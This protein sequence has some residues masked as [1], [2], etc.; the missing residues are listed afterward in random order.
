MRIKSMTATFGRLA[1]ESLELE[2]GLNLI[3]APNESGKSTWCAFLKAMFYG[4]DTRDRDRKGYLADKN[5]YQP[6]SGAP[7]AGEMT[8]EWRGRDITL[9]RG[10]KGSAPFAAFSAVY[11]GTEEAVSGLT[12]ENCGQVL[13]GAG[14][15]MYERAAFLGQSGSLAITSAP[16]LE[17]RIA[18]LVSSGEEDVSFSQAQGRLREWLNRRKVN[19]SVGRIPQLEEE[20]ARVRSQRE[21]LEAL[22]GEINRSQARR[23]ELE[24]RCRELA[25]ELEIHRRLAR[26]DLNRRFA[27]AGAE[28]EKARRELAELESAAP[29]PDREELKRAQGELSYLSALEPEIRG[30]EEELERAEEELERAREQARDGRFPGQSVEEAAVSVKKVQTD[31]AAAEKNARAYGQLAWVIPLAAGLISVVM[32]GT[33]LLGGASPASVLPW[34]ALLAAGAAFGAL[35]R[36][37]AQKFRRQREQ[38][39]ARFSVAAPEELDGVLEGYRARCLRAEQAEQQARLARESLSGRQARRERAGEELLRF[40]RTFAPETRDLSGCSAALSGA[41]EL[42]ERRAVARARLEGARRL[43][44]ELRAQGGQEGDTLEYLAPPA[45]T[46][47]QTAALLGEAQ[48]RLEQARRGLDMAL[49]RQKAVGD[50]AALAAR[51]EELEEEL[52]RRERE[53]RAI[54]LAMDALEQANGRLQQR[55]S[56]QLNQ[57]AAQLFSRLTGGAYTR[58]SLTRE[59]EAAAAGEEDV[60]P[61]RSLFLSKGTVDQ[62]Y[63]AVRLAVYELCLEESRPPLVL[64]DALAAFDEARMGRAMELLLE[65]SQRE[66]I[67]LFTCHERERRWLSGRGGEGA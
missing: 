23:L 64:D 27:Q 32:A 30:G 54:S 20:L 2:S 42:E 1:G 48:A 25:E 22:N 62:L 57:R 45:R 59:L 31:C 21:E 43:H 58:L 34:L 26:H 14:R 16:E 11:A 29:L 36:A 49:G 63:L 40:V 52:A 53:Y 19:K 56:P 35:Q 17:R 46:P 28:L 3:Q 44:E 4:I 65:L 9:R 50:P 15:E 51:Q 38:L 66:Q 39:L 67:L 18:A 61:R 10:P 12:G 13:L 7:M 60:L 33:G 47:E 37:R 55:F 8:L 6:W 24:G 41:L 5:R